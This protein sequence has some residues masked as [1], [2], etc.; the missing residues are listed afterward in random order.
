MYVTDTDKSNFHGVEWSSLQ[1]L[2]MKRQKI[3]T[4][5]HR[6]PGYGLDDSVF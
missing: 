6:E 4:E 3:P 2:T 1:Y 5:I